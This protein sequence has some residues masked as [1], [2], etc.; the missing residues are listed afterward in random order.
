MSSTTWENV[1]LPSSVP[2]PAAHQSAKETMLAELRDFLAEQ[3]R[4]FKMKLDSCAKQNERN[5]NKSLTAATTKLDSHAKQKER[6]LNKSLTAA[7]EK[8][9]DHARR[10]CTGFNQKQAN[11][12]EKHKLLM[13]E[14]ESSESHKHELRVKG[15]DNKASQADESVIKLSC[16]I[17][18]AEAV[19][20][21]AT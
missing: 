14:L 1:N 21:K 16:M 4:L 2:P 3:E 18:A 8:Q 5:M 13:E 20:A 9:N 12:M 17:G 19:A 15:L 10:S 7:A 6:N 11:Q